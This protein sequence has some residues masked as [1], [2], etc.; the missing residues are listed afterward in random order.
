MRKNINQ[1][2]WITILIS[3]TICLTLMAMIPLSARYYVLSAQEAQSVTLEVQRGPLRVTIAGRGEPV[4]IAEQRED[5]PEETIVATDSTAGRLVIHT[6]VED[7][8]VITTVQ[9]Y[10]HTQVR[11]ISARSP[12]Y[13]T[14]RL[15][16]EVQLDVEAGR[17]RLNIVEGDGRETV[18]NVSTPHGEASLTT[19]S[20]EI[21][22][23]A[24]TAVT[25][26]HGQAVVSKDALSAEATS[27]EMMIINRQQ[28]STP[29]T[30]AH[31]LIANGDFSEPLEDT[32]TPYNRDIQIEGESG[33]Q[34]NEIE[35]EGM[36]AAMIV[37]QGLGHAETGITQQLDVDVS[38][39]RFLQ[40]HML[41]RVKQ[42]DVPVCGTE[43][44]ECPVMVRIDYQDANGADQHWIQGFY[45]LQ[46]LNIPGNPSVCR[47]CPT[48]NPHIQVVE[49]T[50]YPY[51][52]S[53]LIPLLSSQDGE[54]PTK[55]TSIS[56]Y[57]SGH[58]YES[59]FASVELIGE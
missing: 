42:H 52:S 56:I 30:A 58:S 37:R 19:G 36:H 39:L 21:R 28:I 50:W 13:E 57:A 32:W 4:A 15:P 9:L 49:D 43:G 5:I 27:D 23:N 16:H 12:R 31:N 26:F 29:M 10:D 11:L 17:V 8:P 44:S 7:G 33:G 34:V 22:V 1:I 51:L 47:T 40:L 38:D 3:F 59:Y 24:T 53:N 48:R 25:V 41:L 45:W 18:V 35:T 46:D 6:P 54:A 55:I 20:Y 2:A 14:S